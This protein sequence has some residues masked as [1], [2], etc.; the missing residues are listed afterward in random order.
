VKIPAGEMKER[1]RRLMAR[2][3][4]QIQQEHSI[5]YLD[6]DAQI[7]RDQLVFTDGVHMA[8][9]SAAKV[10]SSIVHFCDQNQ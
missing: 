10:L 2:S 3:I 4:S 5:R 1:E 7:P 6:V 8:P 9:E